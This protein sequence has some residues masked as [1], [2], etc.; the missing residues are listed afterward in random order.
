MGAAVFIAF[1]LFVMGGATAYVGD[2]L[3]SYIGKKR[4]ST[5]GL[6]P[7][8]TA[9]LWT[10]LSGGGIAVVTLLLL[11]L[12]DSEFKTA[13][14]RGPQ[15]IASETLLERQNAVLTRRNLATEQQAQADGLR[16]AQAQSNADRAQAQTDRARQTLASVAGKLTLAQ[17]NLIRSQEALAHRQAALVGAQRQ[18]AAAQS[19][20]GATRQELA[21]ARAR[22]Q[23]ARSGVLEAQRQYQAAN[24]QLVAA[25]KNVLSLGVQQDR[26]HAEND[27]LLR[28]N[29]RQQGLLQASLGHALIFRHEEELGRTVVSAAQPPDS[30]RRE[31]AVFLDQVE[32]TARKRGA[33]GLDNSPAV[34]IPA[35]GENP[36]GGAAAREAALDALTQNIAEKGGFFPSIVVVARARDNTFGGETVKLDLRPYA[37]VMIFPKGTVIASGRI[38]GGQAEDVILKRLQSFLTQSVR[39]E[40]LD[41]G[42]IPLRDPLSG[43]ALVGQ[44]IDSPA[45]LALVKQIQQAGSDARITAAAAE[46]TYSGDLL[47]LDLRVVEGDTSAPPAAA[48]TPTEKGKLL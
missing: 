14:L 9:L 31:L 20:L 4:R 16:A 29:R 11:F 39:A 45:T 33:G 26:L 32:L 13:L 8:H 42:I 34:L 5:F 15:L 23:S 21:D 40:A 43:E 17:D 36:E 3:G 48:I 10:V 18:L 2:R 46:D 6:R 47:R 41:K 27:Q 12:L 35:L 38:D 22:V 7:R 28:Q 24:T 30:L 1:V 19:G 37:N 25:S 44:P